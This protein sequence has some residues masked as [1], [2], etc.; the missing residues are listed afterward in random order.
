[1]VLKKHK[2]QRH[3]NYHEQE[4]VETINYI[5]KPPKILD[6]DLLKINLEVIFKMFKEKNDRTER[7]Q[8]WAEIIKRIDTLKKKYSL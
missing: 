3:K 7:C 6:K 4:S 8:K 2:I 5:W 1:M